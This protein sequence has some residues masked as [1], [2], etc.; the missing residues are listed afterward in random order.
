MPQSHQYRYVLVDFSNGIFYLGIELCNINDSTIV[1]CFHIAAHR[2]VVVVGSYG[3][4]RYGL[5]E[6]FHI[7]FGIEYLH[8]LFH[9][10]MGKRI[11]FT[12]QSDN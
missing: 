10:F 7:C 4:K 12:T 11:K 9:V 6:V 8:D 2:Q 3:S 1:F 5:S